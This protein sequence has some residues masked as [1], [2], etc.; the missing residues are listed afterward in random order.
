MKFSAKRALAA[1]ATLT[2]VGSFARV[3]VLLLESL[4]AVRDERQQDLELID[5]CQQ[6]AARSSMKMRTACIQAQADRASPI[7]L[8]AVLRAFST[9]F[10]D[11]SDSVSTPGKLCVLLLF[12]VCSLFTP[13]HNWM[14]ALL[15]E[16]AEGSRHVVVV[17]D[18]ASR[19]LMGPR[20]RLKRV[21]G[22]LRYRRNRA[23]LDYGSDV[24]ERGES[25]AKMIDIDL[26]EC[27]DKCD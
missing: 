3:S 2:A 10:D 5:L 27:H 11:F 16:D 14:R 15:P 26:S 9:A 8:K 19:V 17:A 20:Q 18:D 22:A 1:C 24:I 21:V 7:L 6:G 23:L 13:M 12:V 4:A 25:Q